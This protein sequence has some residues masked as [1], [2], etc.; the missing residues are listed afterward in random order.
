MM[1]V[2]PSVPLLRVTLNSA[3]KNP[4]RRMRNPYWGPAYSNESIEKI[5]K[6]GKL[7]YTYHENIEEIVAKEV[8]ANKVVGWFQGKMEGGPR[9]LGNR[10]ILANPATPGM[11]DKVNLLVKNRERWRP[12]A[13][14]VC[15][16]NVLDYFT[17]PAHTP[18]MILTSYV[19]EEKRALL[20]AIT[21]V[22]GE[23]TCSIRRR[24]G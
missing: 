9:A 24:S 19:L 1:E 11:N 13:P 5:L 22:D 7:E 12:F 16:E 21:H 14:A 3:E 18:Y 10:S 20:P 17:E 8:A 2:S 6:Y 4:N 23:R 15:A